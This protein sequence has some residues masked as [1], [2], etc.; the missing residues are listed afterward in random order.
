M[1]GKITYKDLKGYAIKFLIA[2][3]VFGGLS[4]IV[5]IFIIPSMVSLLLMLCCLGLMAYLKLA[6]GKPATQQ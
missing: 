6:K 4:G 2:W 5:R 1:D 3:L